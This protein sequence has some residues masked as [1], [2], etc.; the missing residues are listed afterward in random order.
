MGL[1]SREDRYRQ[2][3]DAVVY[4]LETAAGPTSFKNSQKWLQDAID[5]IEAFKT[6][7]RQL[8]IIDR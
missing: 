8:A 3:M 1:L 7:E 2:L 6:V 5:E 4:R